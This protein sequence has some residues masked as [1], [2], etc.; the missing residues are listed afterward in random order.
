MP[1]EA[2]AAVP[3]TFPLRW[4]SDPA[5]RAA[6]VAASLSDSAGTQMLPVHV[7]QRIALSEPLRIGATYRLA[8]SVEGPDARQIL[9]VTANLSDA[10]GAEVG[11]LASRFLLVSTEVGAMSLPRGQ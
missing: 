3:M 9:R 8:L 7:E 11:S 2:V 6:L 5:I 4:L 1:T 10:Q